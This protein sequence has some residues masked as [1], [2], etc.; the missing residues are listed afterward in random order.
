MRRGVL[1]IFAPRGEQVAQIA[2]DGGGV[3]LRR[4]RLRFIVHAQHEPAQRLRELGVHLRE[5][6]ELF[7][8]EQDLFVF[9]KQRRDHIRDGLRLARAGRALDDERFAVHDAAD[10]L[11]LHAVV[12][13]HEV[14]LERAFRRGFGRAF[15]EHAAHQRMR[16]QLFAVAAQ[17]VV[18]AQFAVVVLRDRDGIPLE[19]EHRPFAARLPAACNVF[20]H[21][22]EIF[23]ARAERRKLER[24]I[25]A[26]V[27]GA[28]SP[29]ATSSPST[30]RSRSR[31]QGLT[32]ASSSTNSMQT[33]LVLTERMRRTGKMSSGESTTRVS[34]AEQGTFQRTAPTLKKSGLLPFKFN[35]L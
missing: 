8:G 32:Y 9:G 1:R 7:G 4:L 16:V 17:V 13:E 20:F 26:A 6:G 15:G 19:G 5:R 25:A 21:A 28:G 12:R 24:L 14:G 11:L 30:C 22:R 10:H 23:F 35:S 18:H 27:R 2:P 33:G 3:D 31:K 29:A 34:S